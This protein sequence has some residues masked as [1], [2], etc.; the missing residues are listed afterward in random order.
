MALNH[1]LL[2]I[3]STAQHNSSLLVDA[4]Y[5]A[6]ENWDEDEDLSEGNHG[7]VQEEEEESDVFPVLIE[8]DLVWGDKELS[9]LLAK[10]GENR[11]PKCDASL[12]A[13]RTEAVEWTMK[14]VGRYSFSA[15]TAVLAANY[16]DRFLFR[17]EF[18]PDKPWMTQLTAVACLSLAAKVEETQVPLLLDLQVVE[19]GKYLFEPK[20]IQKMEILVLSTLQWRMNPVTAISFL[21][22]IARRI[23]LK[24]HL[25]VEFLRRCHHI[26]LSTISDSRFMCYLPSELA[27]AT[28]L[29][30]FDSIE[31]NLRLEYQNHVMNIFGNGINK[32][33]VDQCCNLIRRA[34]SNKRKL[35]TSVPGSPN[36]VMDLSFSSDSES[37]SV[38]SSVSSSP[39]PLSKR[40]KTQDQQIFSAFSSS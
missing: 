30:V 37:W 34:Q 33:K 8:E 21:D 22:Y 19:E 17:L 40:G 28:M 18:Q 25:C 2:E 23:G 15:F 12:A 1:D 29:H 4:L 27:T 26:L 5:C 11:I 9:D 14:V 16:L 7:Y 3:E 35:L 32:D 20:T 13:V 39:E 31:P 38:A 6:E 10:E 24:D 36:G